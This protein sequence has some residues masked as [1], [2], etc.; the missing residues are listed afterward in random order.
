M[1]ATLRLCTINFWGIEPPLERRLELARSQL[2]AL[3]PDVVAMQEVRPVDGRSGRTT[4]DV[5]GE[6]LGMASV[7]QPAVRWNDGD[8][9]PGRPGG[10]EGLALLSRLPILEHRAMPLPQARPTEARILLSARIQTAAG[11]VWCHTTHLHYRLDDGLAREEQVVAIDE[12]VRGFGRGPDDLPQLLCGDFNAPPDADEI[13]FLRGL[14]TL[15]GRRTHFQDAWLRVRSDDPGFTWSSENE[16]TRPLRSLDIDR[17]IDYVFVT[18]RRRDG[19]GTVLDAQV[20]LSDRDSG[21]ACASDHF[22][23]LAEVQIAPE[24]AG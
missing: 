3:A 9:G 12:A 1:A 16:Q 2:A 6:A 7:Y 21:G 19:R 22:G 18:T 13:R 5:L 23:V 20:V 24:R 8:F 14:C 10:E 4:A 15:A 11:P 17:R